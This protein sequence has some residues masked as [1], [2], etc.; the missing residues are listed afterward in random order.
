MTSCAASWLNRAF[1]GLFGDSK[2]GS[3][4]RALRVA[5]AGLETLEGRSLLSGVWNFVSAPQLHPMKESV[6]N[7]Q[8]G[9]STNPFF[10]APYAP[11]SAPGVL[12]GQTGPLIVDSSGNP[13]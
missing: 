4:A 5:P 1:S 7:L 10:V 8:P 13:I 6:L 12:V 9:A 11:S 2:R 3:R